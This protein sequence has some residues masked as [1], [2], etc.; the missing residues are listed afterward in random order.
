M[1]L[2]CV[3]SLSRSLSSKFFADILKISPKSE[4]HLIKSNLYYC[5]DSSYY[6]K[7]INTSKK[8]VEHA[9]KRKKG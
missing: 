3:K 8:H 4:Q 7:V 1:P 6:K 5:S 9:L 2:Q